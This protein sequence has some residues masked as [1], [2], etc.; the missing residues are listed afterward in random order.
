MKDFFI[1]HSQRK[2][3]NGNAARGTKERI[4]MDLIIPKDYDPK[5]SV[6]ETQKGYPIHP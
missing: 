1:L 3:L 2:Y 4:I 5:L 6:K